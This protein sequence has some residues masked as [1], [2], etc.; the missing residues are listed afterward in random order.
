MCW[1][2]AL[3]VWPSRQQLERLKGWQ[4]SMCGNS[5]TQ[6]VHSQFLLAQLY[7]YLP[8]F[9]P[10]L[11]WN[12]FSLPASNIL[13]LLLTLPLS[14]LPPQRLELIQSHLSYTLQFSPRFSFVASFFYPENII[15]NNSILLAE[16][17]TPQGSCSPLFHH[18]YLFKQSWQIYLSTCWH[19]SSN[20]F[21]NTK[22]HWK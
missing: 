8:G 15:W 17:F 2:A 3:C 14:S 10:S 4:I 6:H 22:I 1:T 18:P 13:P 5:S 20:Y 7:F 19:I 16:Y 21:P 11:V 12:S 9:I